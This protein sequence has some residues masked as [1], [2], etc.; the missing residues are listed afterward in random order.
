VPKKHRPTGQPVLII[1]GVIAMLLLRGVAGFLVGPVLK[2][3]AVPA[4]PNLPS[5]PVPVLISEQDFK[6]ALVHARDAQ[7]A[8]ESLSKVLFNTEKNQELIALVTQSGNED[9]L[10]TY[11]NAE[12]VLQA[13]RIDAEKEFLIASKRLNACP[14]EARDKAYTDIDQEVSKLGDNWR[15]RIARLLPEH[16]PL[17]TPETTEVDPRFIEALKQLQ[18]NR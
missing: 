8:A 18:S 7:R 15:T 13:N 17:V 4:N 1:G 14:P 9:G 16:V 12:R 10:K 3:M 6:D 11:K 2:R 5:T